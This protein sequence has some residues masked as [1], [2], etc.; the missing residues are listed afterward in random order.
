MGATLPCAV[1]PEQPAI[2]DPAH[3][4]LVNHEVY[5]VGSEEAVAEFTAAPWRYTGRVTDPVSLNR[6]V[7]TEASPYRTHEGRLFY[8]ES[9][10]TTATFDSDPATYG[11]P[12]PMM[13]AKS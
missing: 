7:P 9:V 2:L 11:V 10:Q 4:A 1:H 5:Y 12:K 13:R 6:F 3:R 8:F